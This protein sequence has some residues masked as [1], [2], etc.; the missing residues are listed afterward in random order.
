MML[1]SQLLWA[2][3]DRVNN[4]SR[5]RML[6][7]QCEQMLKM[8]DFQRQETHVFLSKS[9]PMKLWKA[10]HSIDCREDE[11]VWRLVG[12]SS[13]SAS[14]PL[15]RALFGPLMFLTR[16]ADAMFILTSWGGR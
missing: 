1:N 15:L 11:A 6:T 3:V 10:A 4:L 7:K 12:G 14:W 2:L 9:G 13:R 5:Y 8:S 16:L